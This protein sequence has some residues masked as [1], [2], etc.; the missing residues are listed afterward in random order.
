MKKQV[1]F[2]EKKNLN[3]LV[4]TKNKRKMTLIIGMRFKDGVLLVSDRKVTEEGTGRFNFE[5][6]LKS[7]LDIPL[8]FAA[9]G[10]S[11]K[12]KQFNRKIIDLVNQRLREIQINNMA[13]LNERG[14]NY[15]EE[16]KR[17]PKKK[18]LSNKDI[19]KSDSEQTIIENLSPIINPYEYT[20]E[21][22]ID[23]CG[24]LINSMCTGKDDILRPDLDVSLIRY[25]TE[26]S[27]HHINFLG[28][29]EEL[30][31]CAIGS[32]A[33][34]VNKFLREF[35]K[36]E[37]SIEEALKLS[38]FCIYYVQDLKFDLGVGVEEDMLPDHQVITLDGTMGNFIGFD[39][40]EKEIISEIRKEIKKFEEVINSLP[41][42]K[43]HSIFY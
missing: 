39:G 31:Y 23:D 4:G 42:D 5:N 3:R 8:T 12:F 29:E 33:E 15:I 10:Y 41:F 20:H 16:V 13:Y 24:K 21:K 17:T 14:L 7:P 1:Y 22:F 28:E 2:K 43:N 27:L 30:D 34:Y 6:K 37:L 38:Y 19:E 36:E 18:K 9:A 26:P 40:K 35:W 32:G 25:T 11:H